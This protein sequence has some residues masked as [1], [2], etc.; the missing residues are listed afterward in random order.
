MREYRFSLTRIIPYKDKIY[1]FVFC[2]GEY[3]SV[4]N[5]ILAYFIQWLFVDFFIFSYG[6]RR[7]VLDFPFHFFKDFK[8]N[9]I[10]FSF[11]FFCTAANTLPSCIAVETMSMMYLKINRIFYFCLISRLVCGLIFSPFF[12]LFSI[13]L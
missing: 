1:D 11:R 2:T 6:F 4:K 8:P 9:I 13:S 5:R 3:G 7:W 10:F 12:I